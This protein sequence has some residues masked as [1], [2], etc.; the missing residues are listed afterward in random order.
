[1]KTMARLD[2]EDFEGQEI[3]R[4]YLAA[5][6]KEAKRVEDILTEGGIAY[7]V[8]V[9]RYRKIVLGIL[10]FDLQGA[11]FFVRS[12]DARLARSSLIAAGLKVGLQ[13]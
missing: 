11:G 3:N 4:I 10:P 6:L 9:E 8:V 13:E 12:A 5:G 1:M 7:A 2:I